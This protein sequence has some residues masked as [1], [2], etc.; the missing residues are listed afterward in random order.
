M[1]FFLSPDPPSAGS[2]LLAC[3]VWSP[4]RPRTWEAWVSS[5]SGHRLPLLACSLR[6]V[7]VCDAVGT[8]VFSLRPLRVPCCLPYRSTGRAAVFSSL[9]VLFVLAWRAVSYRL[10]PRS[11]R[12]DGRGVVFRRSGGVGRSHRF[13]DGACSGLALLAFLSMS[14]G[15]CLRYGRDGVRTG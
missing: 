2:S 1:F 6:L 5:S 11:I 14:A 4:P 13:L 12:Q 15:R 8:A 10:P 9:V 3:L 7:S